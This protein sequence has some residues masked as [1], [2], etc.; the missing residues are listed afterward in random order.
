[1]L[2]RSM[3]PE[4]AYQA[5]NYLRM[6]DPH[7][8]PRS[9]E[10]QDDVIRR[11]I[12]ALAR[13]WQ[14]IKTFRDD[15]VSGRYLRK[16]PG[17]Q[18]M[19]L[20]IRTGLIKPDLILVDTIERF[21]RLE[22]LP[23]LR[24]ELLEHYGVLVLTADTDFADPTTPQG[25]ALGMF[26]AMRA[27]EDGRIKA[28]NVLRGKRDAALQKHW[29][30]GPPPFGFTLKR[31][32]KEVSGH[33]ELDY[34]I[35]I[36][37]PDT[38]AIIILLFKLAETTAWGTTRLAKSLDIDPTIPDRFKPFCPSTIGY[39][40]DNEIYCGELVI[41]ENSAGIVDDTRVVERNS[42]DEVLRV[43]DFCEALVSRELFNSCRSLRQVRRDKWAKCR[44]PKHT[45]DRKLIAPMV[46]G[47]SLNYLLSGL[48]FCSECGLRMT[49]SSSAPYTAKDGRTR[50]YA[51]YVCPG[52]LS[53][54]CANRKRVPEE[55]IRRIVVQRLLERLFPEEG[56]SD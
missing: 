52:Y 3:N 34:S 20:E 41:F 26:E 32:L 11:R 18:Q 21:A 46:S 43:P 17:F 42:P 4:L 47:L 30:G 10:Q 5:L 25:K 15:G 33:Q 49:A 12:L 44:E 35:L 16:R 9:P 14:I 13:D 54:H 40:L 48:L 19:M 8:N 38:A 56:S 31:I 39:W 7:Q 55:W 23:Q 51:S 37:D 2:H 50:K 24:K 45:N 1:M 53:G 29:P 36:P 22:E 6:S 28:H 27:T